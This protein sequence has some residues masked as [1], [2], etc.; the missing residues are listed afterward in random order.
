[1]AK[2]CDCFPEL[3]AVTDARERRYKAAPTS[4]RPKRRNRSSR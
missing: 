3:K 1:M 2:V 4:L